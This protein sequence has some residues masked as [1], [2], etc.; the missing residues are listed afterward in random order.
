MT[1]NLT[2]VVC[3]ISLL[4]SGCIENEGGISTAVIKLAMFSICPFS[5]H[6]RQWGL[7]ENL[8]VEPWRPGTRI[9]QVEPHHLVELYPAAA[10]DLPKSSDTGFGLKQTRPMPELVRFHFIGDRW[11]RANQ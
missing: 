10:I 5:H 9:S 2:I 11:S 8:D 7:Q 6:H 3:P 4:I 1:P